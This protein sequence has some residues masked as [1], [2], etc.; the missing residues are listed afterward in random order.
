MEL[1][2]ILEAIRDRE[3]I[4]SYIESDSPSAAVGLDNLISEKQQCCATI[5]EWD[6]Q[7]GLLVHMS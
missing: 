3:V 7:G 5:Q 1:L 2:W 6:D 4:Y